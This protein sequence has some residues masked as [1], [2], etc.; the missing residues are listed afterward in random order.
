MAKSDKGKGTPFCRKQDVISHM[1][2]N[3]LQWQLK[4]ISLDANQKRSIF[5][6][7]I[8]PF[9]QLSKKDIHGPQYFL[10]VSLVCPSH[11]LLRGVFVALEGGWQSAQTLGLLPGAWWLCPALQNILWLLAPVQMCVL[12]SNFAFQ[13]FFPLNWLTCL[14][15]FINTVCNSSASTLYL[16]TGRIT[17]WMER[18]SVFNRVHWCVCVCV[19]IGLWTRFCTLQKKLLFFVLFFNGGGLVVWVWLVNCVSFAMTEISVW[20]LGE[21]C[22]T[23]CWLECLFWFRLFLFYWAFGCIL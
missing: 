2:M 22:I 5:F 9:S 20:L 23:V 19:C 4:I 8:F 11:H 6:I 18:R 3:N 7:L 14:W 1:I 17:F 15:T 12:I 13:H 21:F 16:L 10:Y